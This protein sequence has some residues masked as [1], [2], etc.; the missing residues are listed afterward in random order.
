MNIWTGCSS[1]NWIAKSN[2]AFVTRNVP[3]FLRLQSYFE[4]HCISVANNELT[5]LRTTGVTPVA[6]L[7]D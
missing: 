2:D 4:E 3:V 7:G 5:N 1:A 6:C